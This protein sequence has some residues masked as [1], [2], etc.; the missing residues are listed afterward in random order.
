MLVYKWCINSLARTMLWSMSVNLYLVK[1]VFWCIKSD[2]VL[3]LHLCNDFSIFLVCSEVVACRTQH[4]NPYSSFLAVG[5]LFACNT[6]Q[7]MHLFLGSWEG[8]SQAWPPHLQSR[9]MKSGASASARTT[10]AHTRVVGSSCPC[11]LR[12]SCCLA[13]LPCPA[14]MPLP[15]LGGGC[16]W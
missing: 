12:S 16:W 5:R 9:I 11:T 8:C 10:T 15:S 6:L 3:V 2:S 14:P 1:R 7:S 13:A 4:C